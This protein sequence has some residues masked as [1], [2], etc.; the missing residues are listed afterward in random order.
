MTTEKQIKDLIDNGIE[1]DSADMMVVASRGKNPF[2]DWKP[3]PRTIENCK[4]Y[5]GKDMMPV[6]SDDALIKLLPDRIKD[7]DIIMNDKISGMEMPLKYEF[8]I[9]KRNIPGRGKFY[10]LSYSDLNKEH[11]PFAGY[12]NKNFTQVLVDAVID[13]LCK[14]END[15]I[16]YEW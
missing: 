1:I 5:E 4:K 8:Q 13:I 6:W 10:Y 3:I 2:K 12:L 14:H 7:P 15:I 11:L 16:N 9:G